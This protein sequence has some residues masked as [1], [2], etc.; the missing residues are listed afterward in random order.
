MHHL[1]VS[2]LLPLFNR[3]NKLIGSFVIRR[4]KISYALP[5]YPFLKVSYPLFNI[6]W[7]PIFSSSEENS[8]NVCFTIFNKLT[9]TLSNLPYTKS[10]FSGKSIILLMDFK[11]S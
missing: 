4:S 2:M 11:K 1:I 5:I 8:S 3:I 7:I 9:T 10:I 6:I